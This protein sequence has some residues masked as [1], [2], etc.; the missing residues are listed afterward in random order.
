MNPHSG[1]G[2][3]RRRLPRITPASAG[4]PTQAAAPSHPLAG[5]PR[6]AIDPRDYAACWSRPVTGRAVASESAILEALD[7]LPADAR[8]RL[9]TYAIGRWPID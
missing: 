5:P 2:F 9:L 8:R 6:L 4:P 1:T 7:D 3:W